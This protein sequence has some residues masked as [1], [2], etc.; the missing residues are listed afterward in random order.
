MK[1]ELMRELYNLKSHSSL[2]EI[3]FIFFVFFSFFIHSFDHF[4]LAKRNAENCCVI[5]MCVATCINRKSQI[6]R[7]SVVISLDYWGSCIDV[8]YIYY[9]RISAGNQNGNCIFYIFRARFEVRH[10][11]I[12]FASIKIKTLFV[13]TSSEQSEKSDEICVCVCVW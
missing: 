6:S 4:A 9:T 11:W 8:E 7:L 10:E 5:I 12:T 1:I 13:R 3:W 2:N